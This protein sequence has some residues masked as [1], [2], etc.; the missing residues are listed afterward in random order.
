MY[1]ST[2]H[3]TEKYHINILDGGADTYVLGQGW[4][5]LSVHNTRKANIMDLIM[6]LQSK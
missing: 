4:E 5:A 6:R 3:L 2:S 1:E